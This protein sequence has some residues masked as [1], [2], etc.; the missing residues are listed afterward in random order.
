MPEFES[1]AR[2]ASKIKW[3]VATRTRAEKSVKRALRNWK[4]QQQQI[5]SDARQPTSTN[6]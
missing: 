5:Q 4:R 1:C 3:D 6:P 2:Q